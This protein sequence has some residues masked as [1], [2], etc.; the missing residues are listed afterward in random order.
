MSEQLSLRW[1][2][3]TLR[4]PGFW[5]LIA[6]LVLI[7][8]PYYG[9]SLKHPGFLINMMTNLGLQR[10]AFERILYL[11]PI[12]WAGFMFE[13]IGALIVSLLALFLMLPR[14]FITEYPRDALFETIAVFIIGNLV[15][16]TFE[17]LR[18][19]RQRH[20]YLAAL[21]EISIVAT[22]S[23]DLNK[24]LNDSIDTVIDV[25]R[26]DG[27]LIFL[28][29][30]EVN[31]LVLSACQGV[32]REFIQGVGRLKI[33]EGLNGRVAE[34]GESLYVEDASVDPRV[35]KMAVKE[36]GIHSQLIVP[37]KSK[38]SV[39]GTLS[40]VMRRRRQFSQHEVELL[41]AI[42]NQ[43][44]AAIENARLYQQ[45]REIT[46]QLQA[47][48]ESYRG[49]FENAHDAIWLHSLQGDITAANKSFIKLTGYS[50]EELRGIKAGALIMEGYIDSVQDLERQL[51]KGEIIEYL[52]EVT[53][54]KKDKSQAFVQLSTSPVYSN[55]KITAFQHIA[56]DVSEEKRMKE[57]LRFYL[58]QVTRAQEE[59]RKRI[60][61]EL[62][63][64]TIQA[65]VVLS[66]QLD[67]LASDAKGVSEEKRLLVE[68]LRQQTNRVMDGVRRLTQDLRP[69]ALDRLG[70]LPA[71][72]W[73]ATD[74]T[75][76]S[77]IIVDVKLGGKERR[78]PT[79]VEL[80]LFRIIQEALRNV[81]RHSQATRAEVVVE[82]E[83]EKT[84]ITVSDNGKGFA[85]PS[86]VGDL[87]RYGKL[88][89]A[90]MQERARLIGGSLTVQSTPGKGTTITVVVP[91]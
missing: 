55:G 79:E 24:V 11:A 73:L 69:A 35:T 77:A 56:R 43:I 9:E 67:E 19:E 63:D 32:S 39:M 16:L 57:N 88:G 8:V 72:E 61:R 1:L 62:H 91:A 37:L 25:M 90:G 89:L 6:L 17:S 50:I 47:S 26:V 30:N 53:L 2:M 83:Q 81:W 65:L 29:S 48:E 28:L 74:V 64:D 78:L 41:M 68:N 38:G 85:L 20:T 21:N 70:L 46:R 49:L 60:A 75:K 14:V 87:A 54:L 33:G 18:K 3:K 23:L 40:V 76:H 51:L 42:G 22:Q 86:S 66:R 82:F 45:E 71:L 5:F 80:V 52:L 31:E 13:Q 12:I 10:H 4:R 27:V 7:T 34:T 15:A 59:E 84:R 44:G 58:E 36:E